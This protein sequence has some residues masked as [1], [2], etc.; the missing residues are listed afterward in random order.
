VIWTPPPR[1]RVT[2]PV[3]TPFHEEMASMARI[4]NGTVP[5]SGNNT[6]GAITFYPI[7]LTEPFTVAKAFVTNGATVGTDSWDVG[8]YL[9]TDQTTGRMEL[10]RST[11]AV[12]SAGASAVQESG[13]WKV[14]ANKAALTTGVDSTDATSYTTASVTLKAGRLYLLSFVNTAADAIVISSIAGGP[15]WT[16]RSTTQYNTAAHRVSIWSGVPT[17]DYTG[18]VVISFGA[19]Q[20]SGRWSLNE[21]S[22]VDTSTTDG[23][24]Q[25]AVGTGNS[26]TPLA[27]LAAFASTS[28]ATFGALA[29]TAD[30]TTTPGSGFT[31]LSDDAT[32]TTPASFLQTEWQVGND[33]TVDGTITSGQWGACAVEIKADASAFIIPPSLPGNPNVYMAFVISG[34]TAT[35]FR[36]SPGWDRMGPGGALQLLTTFPLPSTAVAVALTAS[37]PIQLAGF[38]SRS[39]IG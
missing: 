4:T 2:L 35:T 31:E 1:H 32:A 39:L 19:T 25:Q 29:N 17:A 27:T 37:R 26:T 21:F 22:G 15:T 3:I 8:A 12:L 11:G 9:C 14:A 10:I 34:A 23:I 36:V 20:T 18:T 38:S 28:N 6:T 7:Y 30:S 5:A 16:S 33:T 13:T 24:V